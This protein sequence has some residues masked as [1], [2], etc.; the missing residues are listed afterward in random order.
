MSVLEIT[1]TKANG[2]DYSVDVSGGEI[3]AYE[4]VDRNDAVY[5]SS[6]DGII[7]SGTDRFAVSGQITD[8]DLPDHA[9]AVLDGREVDLS[10][11]RGRSASGQSSSG[12][13][14][15][16]SGGLGIVGIV[17]MIAA[18]VAAVIFGGS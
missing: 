16:Q 7:G 1:G 11:F 12:G 15:T 2:A 14:P 17:G 4:K 6:V 18:V 5:A 3:A 9:S 10:Q 13:S 8:I